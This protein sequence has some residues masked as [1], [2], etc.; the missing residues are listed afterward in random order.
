M[1]VIPKVYAEP[2]ALSDATNSAGKIP[3]PER[4]EGWLA[5]VRRRMIS[6]LS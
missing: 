6:D 3:V 1:E 5:G 2:R 4:Y